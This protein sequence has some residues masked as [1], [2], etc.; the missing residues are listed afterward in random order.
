M[1]RRQLIRSTAGPVL[2]TL[3]LPGRSQTTGRL[4]LGQSAAFTGPA[5]ALGE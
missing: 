4:V 2:A 1:K 3:A 5:S